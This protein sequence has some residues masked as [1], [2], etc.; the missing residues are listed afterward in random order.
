VLEPTGGLVSKPVE[1]ISAAHEEL[2][3]ARRLDELHEMLYRRGGIRPVNAAIEELSKLLLL[4]MWLSDAPDSVVPGAGPLQSV[5]SSA[6]L[7]E[8]NDVEPVKAAFREVVTLPDYA[9]RLSNGHTQPVWPLDE[10][11]RISR[12]DII[13][14][15]I[16]ILSPIFRRSG[17]TYLD[18]L[19]TAFDVFLRG[20]Y[21]HAGGLGSYLTPGGVTTAL[22]RLT[23]ALVEPLTTG[24]DQAQPLFGDP[25][26]GTGR[27]LVAVLEEV[28]GRSLGEAAG[29][30]TH[31]ILERFAAFRDSGIFGADQSTSAVAKAR[32]NLLL[33]GA[34]HP[35]IFNVADSIVDP[36]LDRYRGRLRLILTNPPFGEGKYDSLAGIARAGRLFSEL[37]GRQRIDPA[38]AFVARCI[39]LLQEGGVLGI[40]LPDGLVDGTILRRA[41]LAEDRILPRE[42]SLEANVSLPTATFALS[43]TVAKTSAVVLRRG[44]SKLG[45]VYL[46]RSEHVG[47]LKQGGTAVSDPEGSDL[48]QLADIGVAAVSDESR[49]NQEPTRI[50]SRS[51]LAAY[52]HRND[53]RTVDPSRLDPLALQARS[54]LRERGAVELRALLK[55]V[56]R[57]RMPSIGSE[58]FISVL[59]VDE[60]GIIAWHEA[61]KYRPSTPGQVAHSGDLIISLLN[62][63][64]LRASVIPEDYSQVQCSAEFGVFRANCDPHAVLALLYDP[65]VQAQLAPLGRGTSSSRRR[66]EPADVLDL[67]VPAVDEDLLVELGR[68]L[69]LHM[70]QIRIARAGIIDA[71]QA[72]GRG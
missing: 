57:R 25:C 60:L 5:L 21:D 44:G 53:L 69:R 23:L 71:Y 29:D 9:G 15:A 63:R 1:T 26:C 14:E 42:V 24:S 72:T 66:I 10:P 64:K 6:R 62:P 59:H 28:R 54:N 49:G 48:G 11:L 39:D 12:A 45:R 16:D 40:I 7:R 27:F 20:R 67:L 65:R 18:P 46:A 4:L 3:F 47:Y 41:L 34:R 38:L 70:N 2:V 58:P 56:R 68:K 55:A 32:L 51:P 19:G 43:G 50:L 61:E 30:P 17:P 36:H 52:V 8:T 35:N 37:A 33:Y 13:A 31:P 22:A